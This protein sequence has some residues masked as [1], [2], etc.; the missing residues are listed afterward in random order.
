MRTLALSPSL[1]LIAMDFLNDSPYHLAFE[2]LGGLGKLRD[3]FIM[4]RPN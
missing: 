1:A 2:T 3:Q 4:H